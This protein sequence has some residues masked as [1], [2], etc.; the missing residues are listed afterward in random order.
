MLTRQTTAEGSDLVGKH[1]YPEPA[2]EAEGSDRR[3]VK[4]LSV[5]RTLATGN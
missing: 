4:A 2:G 5:R 1:V 3:E